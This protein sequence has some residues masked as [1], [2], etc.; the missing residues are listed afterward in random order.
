LDLDRTDQRKERERAY[1]GARV[2][3]SYSGEAHWKLISGEL[4][5]SLALEKTRTGCRQVR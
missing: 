1:R 5:W 4:R 3:A 2:P